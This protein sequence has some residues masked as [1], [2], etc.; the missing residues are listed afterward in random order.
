MRQTSVFKS[1]GFT[2][3]EVVIT[4]LIV[5]ILT[6]VFLITMAGSRSQD[7]VDRAI[8][9]IYNDLLY[10]RSRAVSVNRDHRMNFTS[11]SQWKLES[12]NDVI[13]NWEQVGDIRTMPGDTNLT[14]DAF[15]NA[16]SKLEATTRGLYSFNGATSEPYIR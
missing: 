1:K 7:K 13:A 3:I 14:T 10:I 2:M 11:S 12:F 8:Q 5:G 16:G 4:L 6:T 9:S 15:T